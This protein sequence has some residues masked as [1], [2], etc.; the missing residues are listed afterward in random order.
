MTMSRLFI[1]G[2]PTSGKSY[3]AKKLARQNGGIVVSLDDLREKLAQ[4]QKYKRW[5]NFYL[6]KNELE[7][8]TKTSPKEQWK[9][10]V[11]QS[12]GLWSAFMA[13]IEKYQKE[14]KLVIFESVN[15]LPHLAYKYLNFTG[16]V[17][18]GQSFDET[19]KRNII[20]KISP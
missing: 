15:I 17:L 7:Y 12:E 1:T 2:I 11:A 9:N 4:D 20:K 19:L 16:L 5:T 6:N 18:V 13:E 3:L 10:L 14:S 8:L